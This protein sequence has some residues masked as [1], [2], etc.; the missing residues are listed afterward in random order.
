MVRHNYQTPPSFKWQNLVSLQ[1]IYMK[2][3]GIIAEEI[4]SLQM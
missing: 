2:I 1:F 3:L 4:L